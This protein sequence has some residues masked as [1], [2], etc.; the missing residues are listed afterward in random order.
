MKEI[1]ISELHNKGYSRSSE[2]ETHYGKRWYRVSLPFMIPFALC[3]LLVLLQ[4]IPFFIGF[5]LGIVLFGLGVFFQF[6]EYKRPVYSLETGK[7]LVAYSNTEL[8]AGI[9][10]EVVYVC[11]DTKTYFSRIWVESTT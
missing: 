10:R 11:H 7:E 5:A 8:E 2:L 9:D 1:R 4:W 6:R 3:I